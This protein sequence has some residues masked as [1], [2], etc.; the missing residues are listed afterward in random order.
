VI[1]PLVR[2]A[3]AVKPDL[4]VF[5]LTSRKQSNNNLMR[6]S[7]AAAMQFFQLEGVSIRL[8]ETEIHNR[9]AY[10]ECVALG[11]SVL[12]YAPDSKAAEEVASLTKEVIECL[13]A[14]AAV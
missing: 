13:S 11:S 7:R 3:T 12:D 8:L 6:E 4:E 9:I 5:I 10:A 14:K 2:N 1:L